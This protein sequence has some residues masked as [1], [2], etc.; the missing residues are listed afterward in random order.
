MESLRSMIQLMRI[1][2]PVVGKFLVKFSSLGAHMVPVP[3]EIRYSVNNRYRFQ[4]P[5]V[6][7]ILIT[8]TIK[9]Q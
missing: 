6:S 5:S 8:V 4:T 3:P 1:D 7:A 9:L 2:P